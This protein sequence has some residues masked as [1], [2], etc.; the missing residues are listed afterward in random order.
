MDTGLMAAPGFRQDEATFPFGAHLAVVSV[1]TDTGMV[2]LLRF[3][4]VDDCGF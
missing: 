3:V 2:R 4:A 1:D